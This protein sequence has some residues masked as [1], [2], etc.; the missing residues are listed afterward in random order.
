[1]EIT[2]RDLAVGSAATMLLR[3][4]GV[5]GQGI[6]VGP[7]AGGDANYPGGYK[8]AAPPVPNG[9]EVV[10]STPLGRLAGIE[11]GNIRYFRGIPFAKPPVGPL[12]F[13]PPVP[14]EA[15]SG[16]RPAKVNPPAAMQPDAVVEAPFVSEDCLYLNIWAPAGPGPYPVYVYIHGGA[17]MSGYSLEHRVNGATFARDGIV[18]VNIAYRVGAFGFL[19]LGELLGSGYM[20]SGNNA[21]RDLVL[22]LEWVKKNI[23]AFGGDPARTTIGGQSAGAFN[24]CTLMGSP[25]ARGLFRGAIS[26]SGG[27]RQVKSQADALEFARGF[28]SMLKS[29]G[30]APADLPALPALTIIRTQV[31]HQATRGLTGGFSSYV[32]GDLLTVR[33]AVALLAGEKADVPILLGTDRD[34]VALLGGTRPMDAY[35]RAQQEGFARYTTAHPELSAQQQLSAYQ[36]ALIFGGPTIVLAGNHAAAGGRS[37]LYSWELAAATGPFKGQA[38]HGMEQSFVWDNIA[39]IAGRFVSPMPDFQQRAD[40]T[41]RLW[42]EF[43]ASGRPS[44]PKVP[45]WPAFN[46]RSRKYLSIDE[47]PLVRAIDLREFKLWSDLFST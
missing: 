33:P 11:A 15:W 28:A 18:C 36:S 17:N 2:R 16:V 24:V 45:A 37:Y 5:A 10:V 8:V 39:A 13:R 23:A 35:P 19:E 32:D 4:L 30:H 3:P 6:K 46:R 31:Q 44:A 22:A 9:R 1:M 34:E 12:R 14:I 41:H 25:H 47:K 21:L 20:G 42:V 27:D 43:I 7:D 38:F 26:Q 40:Y 29:V